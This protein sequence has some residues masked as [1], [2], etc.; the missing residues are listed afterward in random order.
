M[1]TSHL[2]YFID[3]FA[4]LIAVTTRE[5]DNSE[6]RNCGVPHI[7]GAIGHLFVRVRRRSW[8]FRTFD[9]V[10]RVS[11]GA[12]STSETLR[13]ETWKLISPLSVSTLI[14]PFIDVT[15]S[16]K[17][18]YIHAKHLYQKL[19]NRQTINNGAGIF[20]IYIIDWYLQLNSRI[21]LFILKFLIEK[22]GIF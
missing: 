18:T 22:F 2:G 16:V 4:W 11:T 19:N 7:F 6:K 14:L 17:L 3:I 20:I 10:T 13:R 8:H 1:D 15:D 9:K 5:V 12:G 21:I